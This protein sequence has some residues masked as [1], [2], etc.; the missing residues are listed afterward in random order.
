L[1]KVS[2][3][4]FVFTLPLVL[5]HTASLA[6][7]A[8]AALVALLFFG[9]EEAAVE[10]EDPFGLDPNDLPLEQICA[11]IARDTNQLAKD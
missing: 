9:I 3:T 6:A 2:I 7:P 11:T 4:M 1:L 10:I 5:V 8:M